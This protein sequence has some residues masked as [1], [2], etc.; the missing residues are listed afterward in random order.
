MATAKTAVHI[1]GSR[2]RGL[3]SLGS[4]APASPTREV[5]K[6]LDRVN[7][8]DLACFNPGDVVDLR[9]SASLPIAVPSLRHQSTLC[10]A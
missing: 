1:D 9:I 7:D 10:S 2:S 6:F 5:P 8:S 4:G 3:R